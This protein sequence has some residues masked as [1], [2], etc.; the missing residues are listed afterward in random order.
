[1]IRNIFVIIIS[2][3]F[4]T[5]C[6][7]G[8]TND[9]TNASSFS[10]DDATNDR[11]KDSDQKDYSLSSSFQET[12]TESASTSDTIDIFQEHSLNP[13]A[14]HVYNDTDFMQV[15]NGLTPDTCLELLYDD[16]DSD[17]VYEAFA[18][19]SN[20]PEALNYERNLGAMYTYQGTQIWFISHDNGS[21][22]EEATCDDFVDISE[23][24]IG[25]TTFI[26]V[27]SFASEWDTNTK[28]FTVDGNKY[29]Y[30]GEYSSAKIQDD[31][32]YS[33]KII[34][35]QGAVAETCIY[36]YDSNSKQFVYI[37]KYIVD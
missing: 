1:M 4:L 25:D 29:L 9:L 21:I 15:L 27:D 6:G 13:D 8:T 12:P 28:I 35:Y 26:L 30:I 33:S 36:E 32:M 14:T 18:A 5:G 7:N 37:D 10:V 20:A 3:I 31:K 23:G 34:N 17:G 16:Y 22:I 24:T 11:I 19:T 2:I